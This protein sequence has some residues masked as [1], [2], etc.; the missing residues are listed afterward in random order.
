MNVWL[1]LCCKFSFQLGIQLHHKHNKINNI[2]RNIFIYLVTFHVH[3][4]IL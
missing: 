3:A 4:N 1:Q 2:I